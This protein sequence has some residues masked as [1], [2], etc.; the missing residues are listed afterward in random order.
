MLRYLLRGMRLRTSRARRRILV[1]ADRCASI[2]T[3]RTSL[4]TAAIFDGQQNEYYDQ[5]AQ[6]STP[7][8]DATKL[9]GFARMAGR[10]DGAARLVPGSQR[11]IPAAATVGLGR[12]GGGS[13]CFR[14]DLPGEGRRFA[15]FRCHRSGEGAAVSATTW[16]RMWPSNSRTWSLP[17]APPPPAAARADSSRIRISPTS[18]P[19]ARLFPWSLYSPASRSAHALR[20]HCRF[21]AALKWYELVY[22]PLHR[23]NRWARCEKK[24]AAPPRNRH[25]PP[26]T[27]GDP[28]RTGLRPGARAP[29]CCDTHRGHLPRGAGSLDPAPL[30]GYP[31]GM[32]R[33]RD[34]PQFSGGVSAGQ[35]SSSTRCG[36][37][38]DRIRTW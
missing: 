13:R 4:S 34:A 1:L 19:G 23:D 18:Q 30:S 15:L 27:A 29:C 32:G 6:V 14:S 10:T 16:F 31:A 26:P 37:S 12:A 24:T 36:R 8:H 17:P 7:W 33:C 22:D 5:N 9:P 21:E 28:V 35:P 3:R 38:W 25:R 20:A 2:S 11:R